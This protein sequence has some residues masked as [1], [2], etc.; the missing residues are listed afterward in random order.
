MH[1]GPCPG[2][3]MYHVESLIEAARRELE[4][5]TQLIA[6]CLDWLFEFA[7]RNT[8]YR[9]C[10]APIAAAASLRT[11]REIPRCR[12]FRA[13]QLIDLPVSAWPRGVSKGFVGAVSA[14]SGGAR[15]VGAPDYDGLMG[16][17]A[18]QCVC[19]FGASRSG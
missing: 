14:E 17:A 12:S 10:F 1:G 3:K 13:E 2:G 8:L 9:V 6:L 18:G 4:E 15:C 7:G 19:A 5:E 11:A 16:I